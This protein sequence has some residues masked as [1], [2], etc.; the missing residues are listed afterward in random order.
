MRLTKIL[1]ILLSVLVGR[2]VLTV[3]GAAFHQ[4]DCGVRLR[5]ALLYPLTHMPGSSADPPKL[6]TPHWCRAFR[7]T[8]GPV[9]CLWW[10]GR[11]HMRCGCHGLVI[12]SCFMFGLVRL[13]CAVAVMNDARLVPAPRLPLCRGNVQPKYSHFLTI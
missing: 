8:S 7:C 1:R 10:Q 11:R 3:F 4:I 5:G 9:H 2:K 12:K 13:C 6:K